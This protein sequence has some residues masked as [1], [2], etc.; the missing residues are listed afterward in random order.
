M[1]K[2]ILA[3][4]SMAFSNPLMAAKSEVMD[5]PQHEKSWQDKPLLA[6]KA[7]S[8]KK[9][10][11]GVARGK[12]SSTSID[13]DAAAIDGE[14][15][16]PVGVAVGGS[17]SNQEYDLINLRLRWHPEMIKST[18]NLETGKGR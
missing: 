17:K 11:Q 10:L 13:F 15:R 8:R 5:P 16:A 18:S 4:I 6:Q 9:I 7:K 2:I 3:I 12:A 14:R 1:Y